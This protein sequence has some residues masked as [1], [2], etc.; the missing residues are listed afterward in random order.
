M[1]AENMPE[2]RQFDFWLGEWDC[3]WAGGHG[4]NTVTAEL[5]GTVI[6][7][8]FD[9]RP[10][11]Q[12]QGISVS[13]YDAGEGVWRQT[14]ADC[15]GGYFELAGGFA[16]G[17]MELRCRVHRKGEWVSYR[18]RYTDI[19]PESFIWRWERHDPT[20]DSWSEVWRIDYTRRR[21]A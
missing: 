19:R 20:E 8:R 11:S 2:R 14:W 12:L 6:L 7:E 18:M 21:R 15:D 16:A 10:G 4:S 1:P 17:V 3:S 5:D 13:A 9:G